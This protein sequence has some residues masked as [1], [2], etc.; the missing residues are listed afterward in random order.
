V[1]AISTIEQTSHGSDVVDVTVSCG[2]GPG[3]NQ[4]DSLLVTSSVDLALSTDSG[5]GH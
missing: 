5:G 4:R 3:Q 2:C 1:S